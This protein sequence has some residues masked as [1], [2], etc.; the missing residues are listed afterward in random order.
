MSQSKTQHINRIL[1]ALNNLKGDDTV[2]YKKAF[3]HFTPHQMDQ[4]HGYS[5]FTRKEL[6]EQ[7]EK[8]DKDIEETIDWVTKL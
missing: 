6:L 3:A 8:H 1:R 2:R 5:D 4:K 7:S